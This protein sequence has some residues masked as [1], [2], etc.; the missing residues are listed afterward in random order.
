MVIGA[1][2]MNDARIAARDDVVDPEPERV[3]K[4][5]EG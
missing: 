2:L 4:N 1:E 5:T 3:N